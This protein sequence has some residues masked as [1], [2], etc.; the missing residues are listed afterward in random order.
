[1]KK[2]IH[3]LPVI[4]CLLLLINNQALSQSSR[5]DSLLLAVEN[6]SNAS[7]TS[8]IN[9]LIAIAY[10]FHKTDPDSGIVYGQEALVNS[11]LAGYEKGMAMAGNRIGLCYWAKSDYPQSLEY[12]F[13]ALKVAERINYE[14]GIAIILGNIGLSYEGL[15]DYT[16]ALD[17]H[18][19]ALRL[20]E[21]LGENSGVARNLGNIGIV[22]D[23]QGD[24]KS[25]IDY[26]Q[27][28][29]TLYENL[30]DRNGVARNVGNIGF[31]LQLQNMHAQ[32]LEYNF[33][34]LNM[35][36]E[37]GNRI[38]MGMN[39]ANIGAGYL[40][41]LQ[42]TGIT[43]KN[44]PDSLRGNAV[45]KKAE[46]Y[47]AESIVLFKEIDDPNSLQEIYS[48]LSELQAFTG[49]YKASLESYKQHTNYRN[50]VYNE[51]NRQKIKQLERSREADLKQKEIEL[52]KSQ[53]EVNRLVAQRRMGIN[54]GLAGGM[55]LLGIATISIF[56]QSKK[57]MHMNREL[58]KANRDLKEAQQQLVKSE[59]MAAFGLMASRIA[60]EI[61]N[62]LNFVKNF[63]ELSGEMIAEMVEATNDTER[64][65]AEISLKENI[66]KVIFHGHRAE[67]IVKQL[68]QHIK[69]GTAHEYF[70]N[71]PG[72]S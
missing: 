47:L 62:P 71:D 53:N 56:R 58:E 30:N 1:M 20:N 50:T 35:N 2:L 67:S 5:T 29:I 13:R 70:E 40:R 64:K 48:Y 57:Q 49:N 37:L 34:A 32:A 4:I 15:Q 14:P 38:L 19:R 11:E 36:R 17:Y 59:K 65:Q 42:D 61:Q 68:Q 44:L 55:L 46:Y 8:R 23:A 9:L 52:L 6:Y 63:S 45:A 16:K 33:R 12:H 10:E 3:L 26:Y 27:R 43:G 28:A 51:N 22:Y 21:S 24:F 18:N 54:Y 60:H 39:I 7:D 41:I 31:A 72:I 25:A 69:T 66:E